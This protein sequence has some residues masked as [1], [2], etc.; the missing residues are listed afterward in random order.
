MSLNR[1]SLPGVG[2][3]AP[4]FEVRT[5][6][7]M[8]RFPEYS[9][10]CW[11]VFFAHPAN[12]TTAWRMYSTLLA[13]KESWFNA[14]NTKLIALSNEPIRHNEWSDKVRRYIGIYLKAPVIEDLDFSIATLY[15]MASGR[16]RHQPGY[17]RLVYIIDPQGIIRLIIYNPLKNIEKDIADLEKQIKRL[18]GYEG[19]ELETADEDQQVKETALESTE[20]S[21][22]TIN[23]YKPRP[24]YFKKDKINLN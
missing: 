4:L 24:A 19:P 17:D 10:G 13:L 12:F 23:A 22:A 8:I 20:R 3:P 11:T 5:E 18:I 1:K 9:Q 16:R 7:G 21:D 15:G 14:R 2:D 6:K